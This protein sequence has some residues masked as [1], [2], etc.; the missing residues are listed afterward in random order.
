MK[1]I[2]RR[3][4]PDKGFGFIQPLIGAPD[5]ASDVYVHITAFVERRDRNESGGIPA[6][7]EVT[8]D[9]VRGSQGPQAANVR[10]VKMPTASLF[11][12][13]KEIPQIPTGTRD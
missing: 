7:A 11:K 5:K 8:F 6:G 1:G 2:V 13:S 10:L 4:N 9:L 12:A 3:F